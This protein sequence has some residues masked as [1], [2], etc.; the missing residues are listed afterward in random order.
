MNERKW[1]I[2]VSHDTIIA[3]DTVSRIAEELHISLPTAQLLVLRGCETPEAAYDFLAKRTEL[4]HDPLQMKDMREAAMA[5][6]RAVDTE[7]KIA[8]YGDYDVDGVTS[9]CALYLYL[10][11][12]GADVSYYIPSRIVE[13]YGVS[14][15]AVRRLA[16]D[17][18][19]VIVT[20]DTGVTAVA[21]I[22]LAY[23]L[24]MKVIVT[25]HHECGETLPA[26]EAVVNPHR[27]DDSYPFSELAGVGVVFK[28]LCALE[29][30]RNP[31]MPVAQAVRRVC[32]KYADLVAIGTVADVMP[33][34]DENRLIVALGLK[35]I[36]ETP[37]EGVR[38]LMNVSFSESKSAQKRR[39][40]SSL[41]GFTLAP[42]INAAGRLGDAS[43]GVQLFLSED[44]ESADT[45]ARRLCDLNRQ[46][47]NEENR[48]ADA[49]YARIDAEYNLTSEPA[50]VLADEHWHHGVIGIVASRI[51]ERYGCPT[52]LISFERPDAGD[53]SVSPQPDDLG[54]GSG[55]SIPGMNL[56]DALNACS[57]LLE[58]FGGHE[59]AAGL[60]VR[61]DK[62][63]EFRR[64]LNEYARACFSEGLPVPVLEADCELTAEDLTLAQAEE[65][66][67]L[68]PFGAAN[69]VPVFVTYAMTIADITAVGAG[70]HIRFRMEKDG[71]SVT[72]MYFRH[73]LADI[74]AYPGERVDVMYQLDVNEF[75]GV[76][77][78]QMIVKDIR[79]AED[80]LRKEAKEHALYAS[81]LSCIREEK[82]LEPEAVAFVLPLRSD[83]AAVYTV[84]KREITLGHEVYSIRAL[85]HLLR[86]SGIHIGYCK[87][88]FV[89]SV[90]MELRILNI[91]IPDEEREIYRF[92]LVYTQGKTSLDRS[93]L[94]QKLRACA[95]DS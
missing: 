32:R 81:A 68:E 53:P 58:K 6:M 22:A 51:T 67:A 48:I 65:L 70:K 79:L 25:D 33:I 57:D 18:V 30:M 94:L 10:R 52:V 21:E 35:L 4:F 56:Y 59:L 88:K 5:L 29:I 46:R 45:L 11:S 87:L 84:L 62:L 92:R 40:T 27:R 15:D 64:R 39:V 50:V 36:E 9:V 76:R 23:E 60:T 1:N 47:Q 3:S 82:S 90:F 83:F 31:D 61:R 20:V 71:V 26:A 85:R 91:E 74:D 8:I 19:Q 63:P 72:A 49:A 86:A 75:Q 24:G 54:K 41:I 17:G 2:R 14:E 37:R 66:Y 43:L 93:V 73:G 13:G 12:M 69:P 38:A 44:A 80:I 78:L 16:A 55:R 77:S 7:R 42:R 95:G 89:L 34:R 28:L